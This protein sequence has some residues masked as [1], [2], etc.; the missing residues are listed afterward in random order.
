M[1]DKCC[2]YYTDTGEFI[3]LK[4][5]RI[6]QG[7]CYLDDSLVDDF[8]VKTAPEECTLYLR[9]RIKN[10]E[11]ALENLLQRISDAD[12]IYEDDNGECGACIGIAFDPVG[13]IGRVGEVL[14]ASLEKE[15][16]QRGRSG[17]GCK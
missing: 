1:A 8:C 9:R 16:E 11:A 5:R 2:P 15:T 7:R 3:Y 4:D 14:D 10:L 12:P 6:Q 17:S 13:D